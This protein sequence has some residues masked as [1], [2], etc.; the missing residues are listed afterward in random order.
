MQ[1]TTDYYPKTMTINPNRT[2]SAF[3]RTND[4]YQHLND[5]IAVFRPREQNEKLNWRNIQ[6]FPVPRPGYEIPLPNSDYEDIL[7]N[8]IH[9]QLDEHDE[10]ELG[11]TR[12]VKIFSL[13]QYMIEYQLNFQEDLA[14]EKDNI[15]NEVV[16]LQQEEEDHKK[17]L[18]ENFKKIEQLKEKNDLA[19]TKNKD[20]KILRGNLNYQKCVYCS[21][22]FKDIEFLETHLRSKHTLEIKNS[23]YKDQKL[24]DLQTKLNDTMRDSQLVSQQ[25]K[26]KLANQSELMTHMKVE[27]EKN[28]REREKV[29]K[30]YLD[31]FQSSIATV[32]KPSQNEINKSLSEALTKNVNRSE[33]DNYDNKL[34]DMESRFKRKEND[35]EKKLDDNDKKIQDIK[36]ETTTKEREIESLVGNIQ[37]LEKQLNQ[38]Q[39]PDSNQPINS[40]RAHHESQTKPI[41]EASSNIHLSNEDSEWGNSGFN[42]PDEKK[43]VHKFNNAIIEEF[44]EQNKPRSNQAKQNIEIVAKAAYDSDKSYMENMNKHIE[45]QEKVQ[46]IED[47]LNT[48]QRKFEELKRN[49]GRNISNSP[50]ISK[51]YQSESERIERSNSQLKDKSLAQL[52]KIHKERRDKNLNFEG[53]VMSKYEKS[54]EQY[55]REYNNL[56]TSALQSDIDYSSIKNTKEIFESSYNR[57]GTGA[58]LKNKLPTDRSKPSSRQENQFNNP[59][60]KSKDLYESELF[61][62]DDKKNNNENKK[63]ASFA[64]EILEDDTQ[65]NIAPISMP[66]RKIKSETYSSNENPLSSARNNNTKLDKE[67]K[68]F[69]D[70]NDK[71][72]QDMAILNDSDENQYHKKSGSERTNTKNHDSVN[73]K[74]I[75]SNRTSKNIESNRTLK[76]E[77]TSRNNL[78]RNSDE[79][80]GPVPKEN[81]PDI[82][83]KKP[84]ELKKTDPYSNLNSLNNKLPTNSKENKEATSPLT[85]NKLDF[86]IEEPQKFIP[87]NYGTSSVSFG[88]SAVDSNILPGTNK[89]LSPSPSNPFKAQNKLIDTAKDNPFKPNTSNPS[90]TFSQ[91][92][93]SKNM[94]K[95]DNLGSYGN[96]GKQ[97]LGGS[98]SNNNQ[99]LNK[100]DEFDELADW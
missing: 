35:M 50:D 51:L 11:S 89:S 16:R 72:K 12:M 79:N 2:N 32:L 47:K 64:N 26:E 90:T 62:Q 49:R 46:T 10:K 92:N 73:H 19:K 87:R 93:N 44:P 95:S 4:I 33:Q 22:I 63:L 88:Q 1:S 37:H 81:K 78:D 48:M 61:K 7:R 82:I 99:N 17:M 27:F 40:L 43:P 54:R 24:I 60:Q 57:P 80:R 75:D 91:A 25:Y 31:K 34:R 69:K 21:K 28:E 36:R 15:E 3:N 6:K 42:N 74:D 96:Q 84:S 65:E 98:I 97:M 58:S 77:V 55:P 70:M 18:D 29:F 14:Y 83:I 66:K 9:S 86:N 85:S 45:K 39:A 59:N 71:Y 56:Q 100:I 38:Q 41:P 13:D 53:K 52:Q 30:D 8:I 5:R 23:A 68:K 94:F 67:A 20:L 76:N